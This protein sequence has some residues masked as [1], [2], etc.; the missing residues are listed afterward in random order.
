MKK[1]FGWAREQNSFQSWLLNLQLDHIMSLC[2]ITLL[3]ATKL[4]NCL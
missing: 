2:Y 1:R 3:T 4:I